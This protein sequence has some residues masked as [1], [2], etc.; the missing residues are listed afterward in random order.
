M[1]RNLTVGS[2]TRAIVMFAIPLLIGNVFQQIYQFTDAAVVGRLIGVDALAAVGASGSL[3]FLL[4]GFTFGASTGLAIPVARAFGA[5]DQAGVRRH[6]AAGALVSAVVAVAITAVG[7]FGARPLLELM[8]TPPELMADATTFLSVTFWGAA[9][10]MAFNFL[11]SVIRALGDSRTPLVFLVIACVLN[12]ILVVVFIAGLGLG[13]AGAALATVLAQLVAVVLCVVLIV[14]RMPQLQLRRE[15]FDLRPGELSETSRIGLTMGFQMSVIA[16]G[17][18]VLQY[19]I[20]GLGSDAVAAATA[21]IRVDQ[22]AVAPLASFGMA[23]TTFVA[24]N[25]GALQWRRIRVGVLRT[26]FVTWGVAVGLGLV[27]IAFGSPIVGLFVG[28]GEDAVVAMAHDYLVIN[29]VM[30][31]VLASLFLLRNAIQGLGATGV[32]TLAGFMEL[33]LRAGAGVFLVGQFGF[34]GVALAAPLAWL[35]ALIPVALAWFVHRRR[36]LRSELGEPLPEAELVGIPA[37][38]TA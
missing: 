11:S 1:S 6:V 27:I 38:A 10:T 21:A 35:G 29:A 9:A 4:L 28:E 23:I 14:R 32:P 17:T 37:L 22:L 31:P 36:L 2:P 24:Q 8:Q 26:S 19:A 7:T 30:Y 20:N 18:V 34:L 25:R 16:I 33:I 3:V 5:G 12:V 15:D 13:V